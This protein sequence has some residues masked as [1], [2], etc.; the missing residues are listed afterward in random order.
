[1]DAVK[2]GVISREEFPLDDPKGNLRG[3]LSHFLGSVLLSM[4]RKYAIRFFSFPVLV[5]FPDKYRP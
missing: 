5:I 2:T 4:Q 3:F 1:M